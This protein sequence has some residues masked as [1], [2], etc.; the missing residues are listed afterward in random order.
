[1]FPSS[2]PLAIA[3]ISFE[4]L[5]DVQRARRIAKGFLKLNQTNLK[6]WNGKR[7]RE[8]GKRER[9]RKR[10]KR[11]RER[12]KKEREKEQRMKMRDE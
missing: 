7:E 12:G 11:E 9:E 4:A 3:Y 6:L 2:V 1:M 8:R 10:K 5:H